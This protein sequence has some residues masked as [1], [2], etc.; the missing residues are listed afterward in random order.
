MAA[1]H[2]RPL[3][4]ATIGIVLLIG[5]ARPA[6]AVAPAWG[7]VVVVGS[8]TASRQS[9]ARTATITTEYLHSVTSSIDEGDTHLPNGAWY[10]RIS[11][12]GATWSKVQR[13]N[14]ISHVVGSVSLATAG[15]YVFTTWVRPAETG[16]ARTLYVRRNTN[17]GNL[18]AWSGRI[19]LT[20]MT[21]RIDEPSIAASGVHVFV[22]YTNARTGTIRL[23]SSHDRGRTWTAR[24]VGTTT[25]TAPVGSC[26]WCLPNTRRRT[27]HSIV[28]AT[29]RDVAVFWV[30]DA[31]GSVTGRLSTDAG[32]HWGSAAT[33]GSGG[34]GGIPSASASGGRIVV[35]WSDGATPGW[36]RVWTG[37]SWGPPTSIP[38][39]DVDPEPPLGYGRTPTVALRGAAFL[40]VAHTVV[41]AGLQ[42]HSTLVWRESPNGGVVWLA[43]ESV[44]IPTES[45]SNGT[46][47]IVWRAEA[48]RVQWNERNE[49]DP[50]VRFRA[51][52]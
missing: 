44:S 2:R 14:P 8:E 25:A 35:A 32:A 19:R 42:G 27:G 38:P 16:N 22:A 39:R 46:A 9:L 11:S 41:Y 23:Q 7:P 29:G 47:S 12:D 18:G 48:L 33:L 15:R 51:R 4:A 21:A 50:S 43:D 5:T 30:S 31:A 10:R 52:R 34:S 36:F 6:F 24:S 3:S 13:L 17:H 1:H 37:G 49:G 45:I 40:G 26:S 28:V 20:S